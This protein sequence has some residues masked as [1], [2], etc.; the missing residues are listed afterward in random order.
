MLTGCMVGPDYKRP[1]AQSPIEFK[2]L[3]GW[4]A[5]TPMDTI[6][7]GSWWSVYNDPVLNGLEEQVNVSNQTVKQ[8]EAAYRAAAA[9]VQVARASLF[10]VLGLGAGV[11]GTSNGS[12]TSISGSSGGRGFSSSSSGRTN[13][14]LELNLSWDLDVWGRI[15]RQIEGSAAAA[16]V[17]A[18]DLANAQL[19]AQVSLAT[20]Y[21]ELRGSDALQRLLDDTVADYERS[22]Q[23]TENQY[24]AGT[25]ARSDVITAQ[26]QLETTWAQAVNVGVARAQFEHAIAVLTGH[27]PAELTI[28]PG[29]LATEVPVAPASLPSTLLERRPDIAA[30]ERS[31]AQENALIGV[32][33]AAYYPDISLSALYGYVGSPLGSLIQA[34]NRVWSLGAAANE[35]L[36][37]GGS[38][39]AAVAAAR[40]NYDASVASYRQTVLTSFQQVEDQL[41]TLRIL[42]QQADVQDRAVRLARQAV[43]VA[44]N[45]YRAGTVAYTT[46]VTNQ[47]TA[48]ADEQAAL[49]IRMQRLEASTTLIGALGGGWE[50]SMLHAEA[51]AF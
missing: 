3:A 30:A 18:A 19:A 35:T 47:A 11:T 51:S 23:I 45:E 31:M 10:P 16:Q 22:L 8:A 28:V 6:P 12:L 4:T 9:N 37:E 20:D 43:Q 38:R 5:A 48:L 36:F 24:N 7:R 13:Y 40:A 50:S 34:T 32:Q 44:L 1:D 2:E 26:T 33:V 27:A 14:D 42:Q 25:A 41:S 21:F 29:S 39:P 17:S 49:T 46:V 15:R